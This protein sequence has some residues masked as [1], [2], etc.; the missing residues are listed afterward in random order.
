MT[1]FI[2]RF[3]FRRLSRRTA[4][5]AGAAALL[6]MLF[7]Y[8]ALRTGPLAPVPV[9]VTAVQRAP[10]QPQLFGLGNVEARRTAR[11]GPTAAGRV[12]R[13][14]VDVGD[15]VRAGQLLAE[16]D[17]VDLDAKVA[18][19]QA[20]VVRAR[21]IFDDA[22][23]RREHATAEAKRYAELQGVGSS[24]EETATARAFEQRAAQR[25]AAAARADV[26]RLE[27]ELAAVRLQRRNLQLVATHGGIVS[28]RTVDAGSTVVPGQA[29]LDLIDPDSLWVTVRFDQQQALGLSPGLSASVRLRS[30]RDTVLA[31]RV[32]RIEPRA[33]AVTEEVIARVAFAVP[34]RPMPSLGELVEVTVRL[35]D[36]SAGPIVPNAA[37]HR[38][39]GVTGVWTLVDG[40]PRFAAVEL[41]AT[42][43]EGHVQV[44]GG[45]F[46]DTRI[47]VHSVRPLSERSRIRVRRALV[48]GGP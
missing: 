6:L 29:I 24:S 26:Q 41:G 36:L 21:T 25:T 37:I 7:V 39:D 22:E 1:R 30:L 28:A 5:L 42:D 27:S 9:T 38:R 12:L 16:L 8:V 34:P 14:L 15:T 47:I 18:A 20:A 35:P 46:P 33:D 4:V 17:P 13:V 43:L 31:G 23:S 3:R 2:D 40:A 10:L 19:Q 44:R 32:V 11:L 48:E 45:L